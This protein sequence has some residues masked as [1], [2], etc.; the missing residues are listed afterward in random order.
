MINVNSENVLRFDVGRRRGKVVRIKEENRAIR[1]KKFDIYFVL[2]SG[3]INFAA[4]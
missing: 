3:F 2:C 1:R 4:E